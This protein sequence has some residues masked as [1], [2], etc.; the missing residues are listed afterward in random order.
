MA[1]GSGQELPTHWPKRARRSLWSTWLRSGPKHAAAAIEASGGRAEVFVADMAERQAVNRAVAGAVEAFGS[2]DIL[3]NNAQIVRAGPVL[4]VTE[5]DAAVVWGSGVLGTLDGMWACRPYLEGG[6]SIIN[7]ASSVMLKQNT[8]GFALYAATKSAIRSITR[9][10]AVEWGAA[11]IRVNAI[12]PQTTSPSF[13][14]WS[15]ANPEPSNRI[16]SEI[17]LGYFGDPQH[18]VGPVAVFLAGPEAHYM[19]GSLI[20]VDGGRGHLR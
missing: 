19:T 10:A 7:V 18:D 12:S 1:R 11:G 15:A 3:V 5:D 4:S 14:D 13:R 6:G 8:S 20:L 9:T 2:I 17:P 16:L